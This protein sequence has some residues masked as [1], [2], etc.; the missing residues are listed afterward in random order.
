MDFFAKVG[1]IALGTRLRALS[2]S[3]TAD[4]AQLYALYGVALK[5]KWFPVFYVLSTQHSTKS[6]T[7]IAQ[8]IGH[9]HP[10]VIQIIREMSAHGL[11]IET[12]DVS[13][14]RKNNI[15]LS[16]KGMQVQ[17]HIKHQYTDVNNAIEEALGQTQ[18]NI[19]LAMEEFEFLL[20]QKSLF[21]RVVAQKKKRE[22]ALTKIVA[23]SPKYATAF[24]A[25]NE[26]WINRYFK[27]EPADRIALENPQTHILDKGGFIFVALYENEAVGVCALLKINRGGY[28]YELAKMAVSPKAQGKGIGYLLGKAVIAKAKALRA[29]RLFLESNTRLAPAIALYH[30]LGFKKVTGIA[31]PYERCNIQMELR[32]DAT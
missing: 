7:E 3:V 30:K 21:Q 20:Q 8:D 2:E 28:A 27:I 1:K 25:L 15:A 5:P 10:S 19:W 14:G 16:A 24:R 11:V 26:A 31:T 17:A 4:A 9:S 12:K 13:D 29:K 22:M 18:H 23:F 32:L 6:V